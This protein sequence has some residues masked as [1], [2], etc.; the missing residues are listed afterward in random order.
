M[1][2]MHY[3]GKRSSKRLIFQA[4]PHTEGAIAKDMPLK[5]QCGLPALK[6]MD[7][8]MPQKDMPEILKAKNPCCKIGTLNY[9][10]LKLVSS[11]C[12]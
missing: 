12:C 9:Y 2:I 6:G 10:Q 5:H 3:R 4:F 7:Y 11:V 8:G 1:G